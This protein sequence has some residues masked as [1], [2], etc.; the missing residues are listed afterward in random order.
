MINRSLV[1][2][3]TFNLTISTILTGMYIIASNGQHIIV[4][5]NIF[6]IL[7]DIICCR[8]APESLNNRFILVLVHP[9]LLEK[10]SMFFV[11][12]VDL[13]ELMVLVTGMVLHFKRNVSSSPHPGASDFQ[14]RF[15]SINTMNAKGPLSE[16]WV[17]TLKET[18][19]S[20]VGL[21]EHLALIWV[22][23]IQ[24]FP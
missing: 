21:D 3:Y 6:I 8:S 18:L 11:G 23:L 16:M 9:V 7:S 22:F 5:L 15:L 24:H 20:V 12:F 17:G 2:L 13:I 14:I 4:F 19:H 1:D 10:S